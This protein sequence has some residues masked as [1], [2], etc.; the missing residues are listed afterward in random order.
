[1]KLEVFH[2]VFEIK[3]KL[4]N[5]RLTVQWTVFSLCAR[6]LVDKDHIAPY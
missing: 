3:N 6:R 4:L 1:M 2:G 5:L